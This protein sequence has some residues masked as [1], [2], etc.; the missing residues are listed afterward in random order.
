MQDRWRQEATRLEP[1]R[2]AAAE[3]ADGLARAATDYRF[4][5]GRAIARFRFRFRGAAFAAL[6]P[7][8]TDVFLTDNFFA[9]RMLL[10]AGDLQR[11]DRAGLDAGRHRSVRD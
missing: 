4:F 10:L 3:V 2:P 6:A 8:L 11:C 5:A 9:M 1:A 7:V